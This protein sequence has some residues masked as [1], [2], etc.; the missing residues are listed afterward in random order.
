[1]QN[2]DISK[3]AIDFDGT[4]LVIVKND[5]TELPFQFTAK[6]NLNNKIV[7]DVSYKFVE[8]TSEF[9]PGIAEDSLIREL[10]TA[11]SKDHKTTNIVIAIDGFET[12]R[13]TSNQTKYQ[14][15]GEVRIGDFEWRRINFNVVLD[16]QNQTV[17]KVL[18]ELQK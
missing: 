10:L 18:Y 4:A 16:S 17:T 1:V 3:G 12:S 11:I 14:G 7:E 6:V 5:K 9:A 13:L 2:S 15:S 8:E